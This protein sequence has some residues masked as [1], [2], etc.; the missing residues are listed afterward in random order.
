MTK[1]RDDYLNWLCGIV[2]DEGHQDYNELMDILYNTEFHWSVRMDKNRAVDG[3]NLRNV[4][5]DQ[6]GSSVRSQDDPCSIL[7]MMVALSVRCSEDILWDGETNYTPYVFWTMIDNLGLIDML[8]FNIN[9]D[10]IAQKLENFLD[11]KYGENGEGSLFR[12]SHFPKSWKRLEIWY[13]M[14]SW[15]SE[16]FC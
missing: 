8:D 2:C 15:I 9:Y 3:I 12:V 1:Q 14:Q 13:Q 11:R 6:F 5:E 4:F 7:E 16:Q 10:E